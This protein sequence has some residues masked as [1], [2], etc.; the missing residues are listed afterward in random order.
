MKTRLEWIG[1]VAWSATSDSEH[2]III[3]GSERIGGENRGAR[4]MELVV[5]ALCGCSAMDLVSILKKQRQTFESIEIN[6][7]AKR[8]DATPAVFE[9]IHMSFEFVG[10]TLNHQRVMR[11]VSLSVEKY[12]SVA[13]MLSSTVKITYSVRVNSATV[14][15]TI[16]V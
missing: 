11:A 16:A 3:D 15:S 9:S 4:P 14:D 7:D 1:G 13:E 5:K 2:Q 10:A 12:C 8:S 6:A